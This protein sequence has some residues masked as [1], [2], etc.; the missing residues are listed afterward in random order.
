MKNI[1]LQIKWA[2]QRVVQGYDDRIFWQFDWYFHQIIQ[3][4]QEFC[5]NY[6][7]QI[8][9]VLLNEER[10]KIYSKTLDLIDAL[11]ETYTFAVYD[12][13]KNSKAES[14]LFEFV[15]KNIGWYWD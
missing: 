4:L 12:H 6:L 5:T 7:S 15:G 1:Y 10:A 2:Y 11:N 3:P 8:E 13:A 9:R 14:E